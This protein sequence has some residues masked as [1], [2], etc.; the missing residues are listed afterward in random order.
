MR[1]AFGVLGERAQLDDEED[2]EFPGAPREKQPRRSLSRAVRQ[3]LDDFEE[4]F[5][6]AATALKGPPA[7][8]AHVLAYSTLC[9]RLVLRYRL[10]DGEKRAAFWSSTAKL[11]RTLLCPSGNRAP[12]VSL[13]HAPGT[14]LADDAAQLLALLLA[15]LAWYDAGGRLDGEGTSVTQPMRTDVI[16]EALAALERAAETTVNSSELPR[17]LDEVFPDSPTKLAEVIEELRNVPAPSERALALKAHLEAVI[18]GEAIPPIAAEPE[19]RI[20]RD[21]RHTPPLFV[22]P[23]IASCPRCNFALA[24]AVRGRLLVRTP[25]QCLNTRCSRWL[26]PSEG[27]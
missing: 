14:K 15:L 3:A 11:V 19:R 16:R 5:V 13:L 25:I 8:P 4:G 20:A 26:I 7:Q 10:R 1:V 27:A 21:A 2:D 6:E 9:M 17:S 12:L 22:T 23:W 18:R 24:A